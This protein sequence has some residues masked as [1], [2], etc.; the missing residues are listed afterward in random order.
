MRNSIEKAPVG[1][2]AR[3][4]YVGG[5]ESPITHLGPPGSR[6]GIKAMQILSSGRVGRDEKKQMQQSPH[7]VGGT[8]ITGTKHTLDGPHV[9]T[10]LLEYPANGM[11]PVSQSVNQVLPRPQYVPAPG[12]DCPDWIRDEDDVGLRRSIIDQRCLAEESSPLFLGLRT[13]GNEL[14]L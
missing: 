6:I 1:A 8:R 10:F 9:S 4:S 12:C 5:W 14:F 7:E 3:E 13:R 11:G 2:C